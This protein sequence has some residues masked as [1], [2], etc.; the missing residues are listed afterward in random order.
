MRGLGPGLETEGG[1]QH[2]PCPLPRAPDPTQHVE[3]HIVPTAALVKEGD[4]VKLVCEADG[5]PAPVFSFY[6]KSVRRLGSGG[7]P[8]SCRQLLACLCL[9][10]CPPGARG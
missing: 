5:N 10:S 2:P 8:G 6:K 7:G 9:V 1:H 3:L 4:D